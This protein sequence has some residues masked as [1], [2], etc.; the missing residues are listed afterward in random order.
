[1]RERLECD[2]YSIFVRT[3]NLGFSVLIFYHFF[4]FRLQTVKSNVIFR[5]Y[6]FQPSNFVNF[7]KIGANIFYNI[8]LH[9][10]VSL[11]K[12]IIFTKNSLTIILNKHIYQII[13]S[14]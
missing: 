3:H 1:M 14:S 13:S 9:K 12:M 5:F 2:F 4:H 8:F 10:E 7:S 6:K 11:K